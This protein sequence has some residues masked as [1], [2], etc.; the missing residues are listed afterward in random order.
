MNHF[1]FYLIVM[2]GVTYLVRMLPLVLCKEKIQNRF[3][4]SFLHYVP[5]AVLGAMTVPAIFYATQNALSAAVGFGVALALAF[6]KRGLLTVAVA[7]SAA[8]FVCE[9]VMSLV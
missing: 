2:A 5:Y 1:V 8:V 4:R 6:C 9:W 3:I 7:A